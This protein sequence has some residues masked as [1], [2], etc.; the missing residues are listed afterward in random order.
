MGE[1][2]KGGGSEEEK[3]EAEKSSKETKGVGDG[4]GEEEEE[5][6]ECQ[7]GRSSGAQCLYYSLCPFLPSAS[8]EMFRD[9]GQKH[10]HTLTSSRLFSFPLFPLI[11]FQNSSL[12]MSHFRFKHPR[13]SL[14]DPTSL[15]SKRLL[16][17]LLSHLSSAM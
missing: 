2:R 4:A 1:V 6:G 15:K 7:L 14:F 17:D 10:T 11:I 5:K 9:F 3:G 13:V 8:W 16:S 12:K